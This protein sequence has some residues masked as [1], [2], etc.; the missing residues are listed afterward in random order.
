M[1]SLLK[2]NFLIFQKLKKLLSPFMASYLKEIRLLLAIPLSS[3]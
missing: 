2:I 1:K 3:F